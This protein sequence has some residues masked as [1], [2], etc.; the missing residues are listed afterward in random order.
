MKIFNKTTPEQIIQEWDELYR[1][2]NRQPTAPPLFYIDGEYIF[3]GPESGN[4]YR[5]TE[6]EI[7]ETLGRM[8]CR[9]E[10]ISNS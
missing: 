2:S 4:K 10:R 9:Y 1:L 7:K 5:F 8:R 6:K 3:I